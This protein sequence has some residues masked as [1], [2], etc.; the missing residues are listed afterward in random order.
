[1]TTRSSSPPP[2]GIEEEEEDSSGTSPVLMMSEVHYDLPSSPGT[3]S[4]TEADAPLVMSATP[5]SS[6]GGIRSGNR[7]LWTSSSSQSNRKSRADPMDAISSFSDED[8]GLVMMSD[9][10]ELMDQQKQL[11]TD[12]RFKRQHI[13]TKR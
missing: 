6:S 4:T 10:E 11:L 9:D 2:A 12:V 1:M 5:G 7:H 8:D 13:Y 3:V